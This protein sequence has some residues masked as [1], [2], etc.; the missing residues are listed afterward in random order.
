M[1]DTVTRLE[2]TRAAIARV[3]RDF[4]RK[5]ESVK[6]LRAIADRNPDT[7]LA[8]STARRV[9]A[10]PMDVRVYRIGTTGPTEEPDD[11]AALEVERLLRLDL[12]LE[13]LQLAVALRLALGA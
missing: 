2:A 1:S 5:P 13:V 8:L 7:A 6:A 3:A 11:A 9:A 10:T 4:G 12:P